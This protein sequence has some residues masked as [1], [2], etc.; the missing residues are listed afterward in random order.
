MCI[1]RC[2]GLKFSSENI[3]RNVCEESQDKLHDFPPKLSLCLL[4]FQTSNEPSAP[5]CDLL[6]LSPILPTPMSNGDVLNS[7]N[8]QLSGLSK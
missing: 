8:A 2:H 3:Q 4:C 1:V 7:V 5:S 6:D